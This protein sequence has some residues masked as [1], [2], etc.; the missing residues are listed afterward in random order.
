MTKN[1]IKYDRN[2]ETLS[3]WT[4]PKSDNDKRYKLSTK[5]FISLTLKIKNIIFFTFGHIQSCILVV[6]AIFIVFSHFSHIH[7][8]ILVVVAIFVFNFIQVHTVNFCCCPYLVM[9][10]F[11]GHIDSVKW[12][13]LILW[14]NLKSR[15][16]YKSM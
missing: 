10:K 1:W 13:T 16:F 14:A 3:V 15:F 8:I 6:V 5:V 2:R 9:F 4:W 11:F 12:I 7:T